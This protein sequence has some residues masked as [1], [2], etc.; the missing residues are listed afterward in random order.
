MKFLDRDGKA[1]LWFAL[2]QLWNWHASADDVNAFD[3]LHVRPDSAY[4]SAAVCYLSGRLPAYRGH[5][6]EMALVHFVIQPRARQWLVMSAQ[7]RAAWHN[8]TFPALVQDKFGYNL[9]M[10]DD[11]FVRLRT[12]LYV[13]PRC[14]R[15]HQRVCTARERKR[16][17]EVRAL[18][19]SAALRLL[20]RVHNNH[21]VLGR[22]LRRA[23]AR[24][25][26]P[27]RYV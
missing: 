2:G 20:A 25:L 10:V 17:D 3:N 5:Y 27:V 7:E 9:V 21:D 6:A 22:V 14:K 26:E 12:L 11:G 1:T 4:I 24:L 8:S 15:W 13:N 18:L 16:P 19:H 23:H